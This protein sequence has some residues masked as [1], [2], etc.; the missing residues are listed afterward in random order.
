MCAGLCGV[1]PPNGLKLPQE[2]KQGDL[3]V[4][5]AVLASQPVGRSSCL[6]NGVAAFP[7]PSLE[8]SGGGGRGVSSGSATAV[9]G[10][11]ARLGSQPPAGYS[12]QL[13]SEASTG[14]VGVWLRQRGWAGEPEPTPHLFLL[15]MKGGVAGPAFPQN[16]S[17]LTPS[18][19]PITL[20]PPAGHPA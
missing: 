1:L 11:T 4:R 6:E 15:A 19:R 13:A 9:S 10:P 14:Q 12:C 2:E 16:K 3:W 20:L 17:E 7:I 18:G 8:A 5:G